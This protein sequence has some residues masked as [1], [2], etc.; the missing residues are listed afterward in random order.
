MPSSQGVYISGTEPVR[1]ALAQWTVGAL[2]AQILWTRVFGASAITAARKQRCAAL[3]QHAR[4]HSPFYRD[5][6]RDVPA[7]APQLVDLPVVTKSALMGAFDK[8]STD[9]GVRWPDVETFIGTRAH[10]GAI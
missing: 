1:S 9:P 6:W 2:T 7:R 4:T 5:L 8:W 10:I 3:L